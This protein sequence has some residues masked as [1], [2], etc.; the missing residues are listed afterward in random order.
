MEEAK[1]NLEREKN[2]NEEIAVVPGTSM[3]VVVR[4]AIK[5]IC[6]HL[7]LTKRSE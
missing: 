2:L 4:N 5:V 3:C 1:E 6:R 7:R